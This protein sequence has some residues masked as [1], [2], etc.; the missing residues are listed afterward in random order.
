MPSENIQK[1]FD[2]DKAEAFS[3]KLLMALNYGSL[4]LM[5]STLTPH[6]PPQMAT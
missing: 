3:K 5:M 1:A 2:A 6:D 4:S